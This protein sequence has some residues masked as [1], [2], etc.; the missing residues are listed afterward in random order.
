VKEAL[1]AAF[2]IGDD[3]LQGRNGGHID[4]ASFTHGTSEQR[5]N[6]FFKGLKAGDIGVC[7]TFSQP[8]TAL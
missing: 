2:Q 3:T 4:P 6:W 7:D 1:N 5:V 8:Y